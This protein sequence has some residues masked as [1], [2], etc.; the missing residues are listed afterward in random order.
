MIVID[1]IAFYIQKSGGISVVWKEL[2][3]RFLERKEN[4]IF[5]NYKHPP[6]NM[7]YAELGLL[8]KIIY[9]RTIC[10]KIQ[11][12]LPLHLFFIRK[13][14]IFHSTYYRYSMNPYAVNIT[15][16]HDFTYEYFS[17]G[18]RRMVHT[19]QKYLAIRHSNYIICIS[20]N[21]KRDLLKY[22]PDINPRK[23]RVIYNG[24]SDDYFPIKKGVTFELPFEPNSYLIF[25]GVRGGYKN[26]EYSVKSLASTKYNLLIVGPDLSLH[27]IALL[28]LNLG[29]NR[30]YCT[31]RISNQK[32]N[33]YYNY[34]FSLIYPSCY[35]GFGIPVIEAQKSGCPVIAYNGSSVSEIIGNTPLLLQ[36]LTLAEMKRCLEILESQEERCEI[37]VSGIENA[38]RFSWDETY[39]QT[40]LLYK[41]ALCQ[42]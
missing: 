33:I 5:L 23:I 39:R 21:T 36:S 19:W 11:R 16:V 15:T 1:N 26:F 8:K 6:K 38:K 4:V 32:L 27:E 29:R 17:K 13:P 12:Y 40:I 7:F 3:Q 25:V 24:V 18:L 9:L 34:A 41:E 20:E 10:V 28:D 37:I 35:E 2:I 14:F 31:G 22:M 42:L 30:Y